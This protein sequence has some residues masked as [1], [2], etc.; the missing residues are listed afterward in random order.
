MIIDFSFSLALE[1]EF[2]NLM[3]SVYMLADFEKARGFYCKK[4]DKVIGATEKAVS[5][6]NAKFHTGCFVCAVSISTGK[7]ASHQFESSNLDCQLN[8]S[9]FLIR[10]FSA[11]RPISKQTFSVSNVSM[12]ILRFLQFRWSKFEQSEMTLLNLRAR[13]SLQSVSLRVLGWSLFLHIVCT[14]IWTISLHC[15][16]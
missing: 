10:N 14:G 3:W 12:D 4:C 7:P 6:L 16:L 1:H 9:F 5:A 2:H 15:G 8:F 11:N 13:V